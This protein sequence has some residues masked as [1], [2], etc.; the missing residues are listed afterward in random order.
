MNDAKLNKENL[1]IAVL[2]NYNLL[3][4]DNIV[5]S[6]K[7]LCEFQ[8]MIIFIIPAVWTDTVLKILL[9]TWNFLVDI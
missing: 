2:K 3:H 9:E 6:Q 7:I 4:I 8:F 1:N 5:T